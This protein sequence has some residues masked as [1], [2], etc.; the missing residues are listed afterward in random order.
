M[1]TFKITS[2][3]PIRWGKVDISVMYEGISKARAKSAKQQIEDI[4]K[5]GIFIRESLPVARFEFV[6]AVS[7][8]PGTYEYNKQ[9][10]SSLH[11]VT[12]YTV[13][14]PYS[15][16]NFTGVLADF[17]ENTKV[18]PVEPK[19]IGIVPE[20]AKPSLTMP[21]KAA[22]KIALIIGTFGEGLFFKSR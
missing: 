12:Y 20:G 9:S 14:I 6:R 3:S 11:G 22:A 18:T 10:M 21:A 8:K 16:R 1:E 5:S 13:R 7:G 17:A 2:L 19:N 15:H 4:L